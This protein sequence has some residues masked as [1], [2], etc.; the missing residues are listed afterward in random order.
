MKIAIQKNSGSYWRQWHDELLSRGIESCLED[1]R[2]SSGYESALSSDGVMW[3][4]NMR[5]SIQA[6]ASSLLSALESSS[7]KPVFPN[8]STRWH[9][10]NKISQSYLFKGLGINTPATHVFWAEEQAKEWVETNRRYPIIAKLK[11]GASSSCVFKLDSK[12]DA[13]RYIQKMFSV[14]GMS[15]GNGSVKKSSYRAFR[16]YSRMMVLKLPRP[17]LEYFLR[18]RPALR[19]VW[20]NERG[21]VYF[22]EYLPGN[23]F[24]TRVTVIGGRALAFR[25]FNRDKDFRASGSGKIDYEMDSIDKR[26]IELA[27]NISSTNRFQSMAYDFL[28]DED[29]K[30]SLVE[31]SYAYQ[32]KAVFD[33]PGFW[34]PKLNWH[35]G[36]VLPEAA[37]VEDF[38]EQIE[39]IGHMQLR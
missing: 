1:V 5:P 39:E 38:I 28:I 36:H 25:R 23:E 34:D 24:D 21:Y 9:F 7:H 8:Y 33:C 6:S 37:H 15:R 29:G 14:N 35:E 2:T 18:K 19:D 27:L 20:P 13:L 31:I 32:S 16:D 10:D 4:I 17:V 3:H 11:R 22:Q 26:A 12:K 30:P